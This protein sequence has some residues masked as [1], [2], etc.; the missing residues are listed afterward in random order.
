MQS[1]RQRGRSEHN[2]LVNDFR[3]HAQVGVKLT[4]KAMSPF[5]SSQHSEEDINETALE[6]EPSSNEPDGLQLLELDSSEETAGEDHDTDDGKMTAE[7]LAE[8]M[9]D[10][11]EGEVNGE[12]GAWDGAIPASA[13][14]HGYLD[15][16]PGCRP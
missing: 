5:M 7:K 14:K 6:P 2:A 9:E 12:S 3:A 16:I 10:G 4:N 1:Q 15:M 11:D 13:T 8:Y